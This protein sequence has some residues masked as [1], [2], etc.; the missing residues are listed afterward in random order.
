MGD[1]ADKKDERTALAADGEEDALL[2]VAADDDAPAP[3]TGLHALGQLSTAVLVVAAI[4]VVGLIAV[5]L[6]GFV[7]N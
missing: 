2:G 1:E 5:L 7:F 3:E 6:V 4:V